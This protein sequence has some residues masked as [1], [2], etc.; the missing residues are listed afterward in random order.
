MKV[1]DRRTVVVGLIGQCVPPT[2]DRDRRAWSSIVFVIYFKKCPRGSPAYLSG[3][4][5]SQQL[6][7]HILR[8]HAVHMPEKLE[9]IRASGA[10]RG[11]LAAS[12]NQKSSPVLL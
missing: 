10:K 8:I 6:S 1:N 9:Q 5:F 7:H 11:Y 3:D 4:S 12:D 2:V